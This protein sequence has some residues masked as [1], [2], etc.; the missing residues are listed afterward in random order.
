MTA[1]GYTRVLTNSST[2]RS[3]RLCYLSL[4]SSASVDFIIAGA[5]TSSCTSPAV[6]GGT[7]RSIVSLSLDV[8]NLSLLTAAGAD[9]CFSSSA[10]ANIGGIIGYL[11]Q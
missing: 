1:S 9:L 11:I 8:P 2:T 4:S 6:L 10:T 7:W 5:A 3:I